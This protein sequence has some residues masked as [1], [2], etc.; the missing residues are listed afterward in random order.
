M[1]A[2]AS[3][4]LAAG[5]GTS[6]ERAYRHIKDGII[7][8]RL[9]PGER[10]AAATLAAD[11]SVSRTP[12]REALSRLEQERLVV[13]ESGW[14]YV[15]RAMSFADIAHTYRVRE[16]LEVEAARE[17]LPHLDSSALAFLAELLLRAEG[18][19]STGSISEFLRV[20]RQFHNTIAEHTGNWV[21][22]DMLRMITDRIQIVGALVMER[23]P[24]CGVDIL[25]EN[26]RILAAF[27]EGDL[28]KVEQHV[29]GHVHRAR[30]RVSMFFN[31]DSRDLYVGGGYSHPAS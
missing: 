9:K 13:R 21:L 27:D 2:I 3:N 4:P 28:S 31:E 24:E 5:P 12:V 25:R 16:A 10:L 26:R 30:E 29:R 22:Q 8:Y 19:L 23:H 17:A 11:L 1:N 14:G 7:S 15:V 18:F 6:Q 20:S